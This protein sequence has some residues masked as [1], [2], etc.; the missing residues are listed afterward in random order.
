MSE[1]NGN[2]NSSASGVTLGVRKPTVI[3]GNNSSKRKPTVIGNGNS[4]NDTSNVSKSKAKPTV[5]GGGKPIQN[6]VDSSQNKRKAT[7][8]PKGIPS[9]PKQPVEKPVSRKPTAIQSTPKQNQTSSAK[10][11]SVMPGTVRKTLKV[12]INE[13]KQ[14]FPATDIK[15]L[16]A[17]EVI[18]GRI[19]VE[20]L[21]NTQCVQWG[22]DIQKKHTSI[23][24]ESLKL[25]E[26]KTVQDSLRHMGRLYEILDSIA[27]RFS[28]SDQGLKFWKKL[29]SP[30]EDFNDNRA[31]I[32]Q[33]RNILSNA[34]AAI[35]DIE[36]K[37]KQLSNKSTQLIV[38][39]D[40]SSIA[41]EYLSGMQGMQESKSS[42]LL[43]RSMALKQ[44][45][46]HI[47]QGVTLRQANVNDIS[48]L[49][50]NIQDVILITLP[51][52]IEK[53]ALIGRKRTQTETE[54]YGVKQGLDAILDKIKT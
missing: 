37:L 42:P 18:L 3:G 27:S 6:T 39:L 49:A 34:G 40:A 30:W 26:N 31:E 7:V 1:K 43:A 38:D 41:S 29:K 16:R 44:T 8:I 52:W 45:V 33:I 35:T 14:K 21:S 32:D 17:A 10:R 12:E 53:V 28:S 50:M 19:V 11:Q 20:T 2:N 15:V 48:G 24:D 5:I 23:V 36:T 25:T 46:A 22:V 54:S 51:G 9:T 47:K 13:L 4:T